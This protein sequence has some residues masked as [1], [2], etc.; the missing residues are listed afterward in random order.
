[1]INTDI[2]RDEKIA[3]L[4]CWLTM[5]DFIPANTEAGKLRD[6]YW[7]GKL[8][9]ELRSLRANSLRGLTRTNHLRRLRR[10]G[11]K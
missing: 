8:T 11:S 1:M 4:S 9:S 6:S 2:D 5:L 3:R 7:R 10:G